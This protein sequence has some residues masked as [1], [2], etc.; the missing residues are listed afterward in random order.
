[1]ENG[2]YLT[3]ERP[4]ALIAGT[5][6][7]PTDW[8]P[9]A[10]AIHRIAGHKGVRPPLQYAAIEYHDEVSFLIG[11]DGHCAIV[12][13]LP[14]VEGLSGE[15]FVSANSL[16]LWI[17]TKG[18]AADVLEWTEPVFPDIRDPFPGSRASQD[19]E[20]VGL[21]I[22]LVHR[23]MTA[24]RDARVAGPK[25]MGAIQASAWRV[26]TKFDPIHLRAEGRTLNG[27]EI[28]LQVLIMPMRLS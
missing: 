14:P 8:L 25:S 12:A 27:S 21:N 10:K 26:S 1:M 19:E 3:T 22:A 18:E 6:Q 23:V 4:S 2:K 20:E 24:I 28:L 13:E 17:K 16:S 15:A 9:A 11:T 5:A 7:L